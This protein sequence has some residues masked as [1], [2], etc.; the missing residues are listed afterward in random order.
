MHPHRPA[1]FAGALT[2]LLGLAPTAGGHCDGR[3]GPVA[4]A[5]AAALATGNVALALAWVK[6]EHDAEIRAVFQSVRAARALGPAAAAVADEHFLETLVRVH[7]AGEGAA[8][9]GLKPAGRDLGP[10]IP[11]ADLAI[12]SGSPEALLALLRRA[13]EQG[14]HERLHAVVARRNWDRN[15]AEAGRAYVAAY[16]EFVHYVERLHAAA[17]GPA[18][19]HAPDGHEGH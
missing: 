10:A 4:S 18:H 13:V 8:Y 19:G 5:A 14:L 15:D 7:R 11:A 2:V 16:V 3:H 1:L 17:T 12:E 6:P 9:T